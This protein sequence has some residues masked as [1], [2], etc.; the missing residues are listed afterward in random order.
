M[1]DPN[2]TIQVPF[3]KVQYTSPESQLS[4]PAYSGDAGMDVRAVVPCMLSPHSI[5]R[6]DIGMR[7]ALPPGRVCTFLTRSSAVIQGLFVLP[8]LID[9]GYRGPLY[10]FVMNVT[11]SFVRIDPGVSIAQLFILDNRASDVVIVS[12]GELPASERGMNGFGSSGGA[13]GK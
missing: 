12:V 6:V 7:I 5:G 9:N 4:P 8:T 10:L 13:L 11:D 2:N 3:L 1:D